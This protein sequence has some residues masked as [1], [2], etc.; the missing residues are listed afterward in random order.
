MLIMHVGFWQFRTVHQSGRDKRLL[1]Q[2]EITFSLWVK[3]KTYKLKVIKD[4]VAHWPTGA[5]SWLKLLADLGFTE[6][7]EN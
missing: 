1:A 3:V 6:L 5:W 4:N 2:V 7:A